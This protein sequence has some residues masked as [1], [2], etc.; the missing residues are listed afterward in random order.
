MKTLL[1]TLCAVLFFNFASAQERK[2]NERF[3]TNSNLQEIFIDSE[4]GS[5]EIVSA[6]VNEVK[7]EGT[8][9]INIGRSNDAYTIQGKQEGNTFV[10]KTELDEEGLEE[11]IILR[12][13]DG[14]KKI[15]LKDNGNTIYI[16][17]DEDENN[18]YQSMNH[19][20]DVEID[21]VVTVP[22]DKNVR[23]KSL[24]GSIKARNLNKEIDIKCTYGGAELVQDRIDRGQNIDVISTYNHVDV[25][26][27]ANSKID[28]KLRTDYG[29][30][31]SNHNIKVDLS[32]NNDSPPHGDQVKVKLNGGGPNVNLESKYS[33]VYFRK[34][35]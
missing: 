26:M 1:T 19:G 3:S 8:V 33:N 12:K 16:S 31:F 23:V 32:Q 11:L 14:S 13:K 17:G 20:Y 6:P 29:K 15:I 21:L 4:Y 35:S 7:I 28:L 24:F 2:V 9:S 10:I 22:Q 5:I 34:S 18:E 27:G 30:I 25:S